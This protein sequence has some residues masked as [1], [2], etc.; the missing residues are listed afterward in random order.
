MFDLPQRLIKL[1]YVHY[2]YK[3]R[4][5]QSVIGAFG[6]LDLGL[7]LVNSVFFV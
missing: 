4:Q 1:V 5:R 3:H 6:T 2:L 7:L